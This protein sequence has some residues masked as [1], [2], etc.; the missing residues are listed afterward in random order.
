MLPFF[1]APGRAHSLGSERPLP[2][3]NGERLAK[4]AYIGFA[5]LDLL[6]KVLAPNHMAIVKVLTG[7]EPLA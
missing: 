3:R 1:C 2:A 7:S 4:G 5:S 6:W